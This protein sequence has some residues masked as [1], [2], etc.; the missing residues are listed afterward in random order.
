MRGCWGVRGGGGGGGFSL[1]FVLSSFSPLT[2]GVDDDDNSGRD[3]GECD[4]PS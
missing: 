4:R 2:S 3:I 1:H